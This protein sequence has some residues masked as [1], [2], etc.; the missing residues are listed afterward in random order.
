MLD[1]HE[2]DELLESAIMTDQTIKQLKKKLD[3]AKAQLQAEGLSIM[4]NR[5]IRYIDFDSESGG[6]FI[7]LKEKVSIDNL[8]LLKEVCGDVLEEKIDTQT[9]VKYVVNDSKFLEALCIVYR[10]DYK[11]HD[12]NKI[13][14]DLGLDEKQKKAA[15]KKFKGEY[16]KD[17]AIL[18]NFGA[19][20][21]LEEELDAIKEHLNFE[22]VHRYFDPSNIDVE[23]LKRA[24]FIEESLAVGLTYES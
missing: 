20:G 7:S 11:A 23:K 17:K 12:I 10:G 24:I 19:T 4:E 9:S 3:K 21:D 6:A 2:I 18:E 15:L 14:S 22:L 13:L 8:R 16:Q 5:N 1:K